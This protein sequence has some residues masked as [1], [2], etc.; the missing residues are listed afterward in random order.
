MFSGAITAMIT[1]SSMT[2]KARGLDL[3]VARKF[4]TFPFIF[5]SICLSHHQ[6]TGTQSVAITR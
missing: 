6:N 1:N 2:V 3:D 4:K 5:D